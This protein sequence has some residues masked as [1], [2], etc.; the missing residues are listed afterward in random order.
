MRYLRRQ[1]SIPGVTSATRNGDTWWMVC[2]L[3][4]LAQVS[5]GAEGRANFIPLPDDAMVAKGEP[6]LGTAQMAIQT[7]SQN[8]G[9]QIPDSLVI[10]NENGS[11]EY[12]QEEKTILYTG[13]G[14]KLLYLRTVE[15][16]E[17]Y[18]TGILAKMDSTTAD[19]LGPLVIY[20]GDTLTHAESGSYNWQT[21]Y[22][23]VNKIRAKVQGM[24][25]RGSAVEYKKDAK[26]QNF[27]VIHDGYV[28]SEDVQV[29]QMW[30]GTGE[31]TIY[32]GDYGRISR[33]S[34][35]TADH[36]MRVPILG[37]FPIT[38]S[39]N[40]DEG[41]MPMPGIK[42]TWGAY[43]RNRYGI[44]LGNRRVNG[45]I[46]TA[47][48]LATA[49]LDYR[50]RR[51]VAGGMEFKNLKDTRLYHDA[52]GL[53]LYTA[54]D[55]HPNINPVRET[56]KNTRHGRYRLAL[57]TIHKLPT[58]R[59]KGSRDA[60]W[61]IAT[62]INALS[63]E[64]MLQDFFEDE[65]RVNNRPDNNIRLV[66][67]DK[68]S[69]TMLFTR[70]A[71]NNYY[72]TDERVEVSYYRARTAIDRTSITYET[73]NSAGVMHQFLTADQRMNYLQRLHNL[74]NEDGLQEYYLRLLNG[75][76]YARLNSTHEV[77]TSLK[78]LRFLNIT[79]KVGGGFAGYYGVD[80]VGADNRFF[81]YFGCDFDIKFSRYFPSVRIPLMG[82]NGLYHIFHPYAGV[83]HGIISSSNPLVPEIDTW[84]TRLGGSTVNPMPLDLME[85]T[86][87]DGWGKWTVWRLGIRNTLSTVYDGESRTIL[88]WNLFLDYNIDNPNTESIFSNLYS[89][90]QLDMTRQCRLLLETQTPTIE[91]GDGFY[92]YNTSLQWMVCSWFET[93]VGHRYIKDHPIQRDSNYAYI[94][95]NIRLNERYTLAARIS[96]DVEEKR[97]PIQQFSLS[98]KMGPWYAGATLMFRDN[99]GK[100][101]TGFGI[102][103][104]LGEI[105]TS[106]PVNFF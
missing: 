77:T 45:A 35:A 95:G 103:F 53:S 42:S 99:G 34:I 31:L 3:L 17:I 37:W 55:K 40:P 81:G 14:E 84:S 82:I 87:I 83:S 56:R 50:V 51:G 28:S 10:H 72:S 79:P 11:V 6:A 36:E 24:L 68:Q 100:K 2:A 63:D 25:V 52:H 23:R 46:P 49:L 58:P 92:Q 104:T 57:S 54:A 21:G 44:L 101:E 38:H 64:Y 78:V 5:N 86:G 65:A 97:M 96:W 8:S 18:A 73:R 75:G 90:V 12:D 39:L 94:Q 32:P 59:K 29:P 43:L 70:F 88:N 47:D 89:I 26:G 74:R 80:D 69:Q 19:L 61:S 85:F 22:A 48:Y 27:M 62:D 1:C 91:E 7:L 15:G 106:F 76:H 98:R 20:Y 4:I 102:S 30:V 13:N 41:Y 67:R 33:L 66:R 105:G 9:F 93:Q 71:P 16:Q 60:T